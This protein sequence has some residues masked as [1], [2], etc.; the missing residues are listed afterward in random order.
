MAPQGAG[1]ILGLDHVTLVVE[2]L[3]A[4][5]PVH[6]MLLGQACGR[7]GDSEGVAWACFVLANTTLV[8]VAPGGAPG[9]LAGH[10]AHRP[11]GAPAAL[12]AL[13]FAAAAPEAT[14]RL[15]D[16]RGLPAA[17]PTLTWLNR[18]AILLAP[19]AARGLHLL[20]LPPGL[21]GA[22]AAPTRLDHV[23]IR[24]G[25][26]DRSMALLA[27]RLGLEL[28]LDRSNPAWG[29]RL[30]FFRC[31]DLVVEVSH[32]LATGITDAP[33]RLWGLTW[34]V[35]D[36]AASHARLA[37]AGIPVSPLRAGRKPGSR[38]FTIRDQAAGVPTAFIGA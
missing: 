27:G 4:A 15:L 28:R 34:G 2:A 6:E 10:V 5:V 9:P 22:V 30:L 12:G 32:D 7:R 13:G 1:P 18:P 3:D 21:T 14:A 19:D 37:A 29:S 33:D 24:S 26:P 20:L 35:P 11:D 23:V 36:V 31:G 17:H 8:L 38:I 25:D 16:R